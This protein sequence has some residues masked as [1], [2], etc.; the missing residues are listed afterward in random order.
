MNNGEAVEHLM[1][2][3]QKSFAHCSGHNGDFYK[4]MLE[5]LQN[6]N[7]NSGDVQEATTHHSSEIVATHVDALMFA[8][9][10]ACILHGMSPRWNPIEVGVSAGIN[11][12]GAALAYAPLSARRKIMERIADDIME[13]ASSNGGSVGICEQRAQEMDDKGED[14][15]AKIKRAANVSAEDVA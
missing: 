12:L 14:A 5:L 6:P 11:A 4:G 7:M 9:G 3:L 13:V 2:V 10:T 15:L 8:H 1:E